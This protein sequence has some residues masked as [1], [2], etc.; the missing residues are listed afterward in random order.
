MK[1]YWL[2]LICFFCTVFSVWPE[3]IL[4]NIRRNDT[5]DYNEKTLFLAYAFEDG[6]MDELF[7]SGHIIFNTELKNG[8]SA[9]DVPL[10]LARE[11]GAEYLL[12]I[13]I[14]CRESENPEDNL[15]TSV[16]FTLFDVARNQTVTAGKISIE[17]QPD[18]GQTA[19][20]VSFTLGKQT[21]QKSLEAL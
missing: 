3:S 20:D 2:F 15:L 4:I 13:Y 6:V 14:S 11:E 19:R 10:F 1:K 16:E 7:E 8:S 12:N 5:A 17:N 18:T 9:D 21:A